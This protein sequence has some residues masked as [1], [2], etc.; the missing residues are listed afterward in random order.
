MPGHYGKTERTAA[1][2]GAYER[3][4]GKKKKNKKEPVNSPNQETVLP[5]TGSRYN[6]DGTKRPLGEGWGP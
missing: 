2:P 4:T 6:K 5:G 1:D 3:N